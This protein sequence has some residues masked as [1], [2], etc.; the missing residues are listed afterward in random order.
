MTVT[1]NRRQL[2]SSAALLTVAACTSSE[3]RP[4]RP[5]PDDLLRDAAVVRERALLAMYDAVPVGLRAK[6][7]AT[8]TDHEAHLAALL[9]PAASPVTAP[10]SQAPAIALPALVTA[11]RA[12]AAAHATAALTASGPLAML[13]A[14]LAACEASHPV[15]LA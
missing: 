8:R 5:D 6:V 13:L 12:A 3:G 11:E 15:A 2:L 14:S 7:A 1:P 4:E 9:G 10:A